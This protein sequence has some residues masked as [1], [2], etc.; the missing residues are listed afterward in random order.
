MVAFLSA[1]SHL[2]LHGRRAQSVLKIGLNRTGIKMD[3]V[4]IDIPRKEDGKWGSYISKYPADSGK[5]Q[6][7]MFTSGTRN[8]ITSASGQAEKRSGGAIWNPNSTLSGAALDQYEAVFTS[9]QRLFVVNDAGTIKASTGNQLFTSIQSGFTNPSNFEF[10]TYQSRVYGCNGVDN[11]IVLDVATSYGGVPYTVNVAKTRAM[12]AQV[13][14]TACTASGPSAGGSVPVGSHTYKVTYVY[15]N[16]VEE[17]NGN[18]AS[19]VVAATT[20]NQTIAL[21]SIPVGGY[22][23][24]GRNIYRDNNDGNYLLL[25][26]INDNTTTTFS[27]TLALGSTPTPIPTTSGLPP[28][29]KYVAFYLDRLFVIDVTGKNII[30]STAGQPD[31]FNPANAISGPQDDVMTAI[32]VFN[33]IPWVFGQHTTG[34]I[35]GNTD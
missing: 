31:C 1:A 21:S 25:T 17:S 23:V 19:G 5:V 7:N 11:P 12:G 33:G 13:P 32:Y 18:T 8:V 6:A 35:L 3:K 16:G 4:K 20:G 15:Y 9:G 28:V 30:W 24:T 22:G 34:Q 29:F 2:H 27:D 14:A 26:S 10:V